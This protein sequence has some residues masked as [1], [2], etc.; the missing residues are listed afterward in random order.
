MTAE[1]LIR[2]SDRESVSASEDHGERLKRIPPVKR[3]G[4]DGSLQ[5]DAL[6][7]SFFATIKR[8]MIDHGLEKM[9]AEGE[10]LAGPGRFKP[11]WDAEPG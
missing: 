4:G 2:Y 5:D 6:A 7:E 1:G 9:A 11:D 3:C 10:W 8:E